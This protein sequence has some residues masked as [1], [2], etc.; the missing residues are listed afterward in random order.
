MGWRRTI[1]CGAAAL[2][3][4]ALPAAAAEK[5]RVLALDPMTELLFQFIGGPYVST[6]S[7][8]SW[9]DNGGLRVSRAA[10]M[11]GANAALPLYALDPAQY[12]EFMTAG[13]RGKNLSTA[14]QNRANLHYLYPDGVKRGDVEAFYGDPANMPFTAQQVAN[15]L[16]ELVPARYAYFQ[17]RLGEFNARLRSVL[18]TGRR[19]L[20][21][22]K[23]LCLSERYRL[24]FTAFGCI[25][26]VPTEEEMRRI[27]QISQASN[28]K[29]I[30][31]IAAG[32]T[33][34]RLV[35]VAHDA[36]PKLRR[37]MVAHLG[38]VYIAPPK[39]EDILF[40]IHRV[41]L[42]VGARLSRR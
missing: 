23:V 22:T 41:L 2:L 32:L 4:C 36:D 26:S 29:Y 8:T 17:R 21:G 15:A 35:V 42:E 9:D 5:T 18:I 13:R 38:A 1:L 7:G 30:E 34:G 20:A 37:A 3:L 19:L 31:D 33:A 6:A 24:F 14:E 25:V 28:P 40:F 39:N 27:R 11:G 16:S 12:R 10:V